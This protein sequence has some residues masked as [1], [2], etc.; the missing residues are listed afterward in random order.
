MQ[1]H[2]TYVNFSEKLEKILSLKIS[3]IPSF[4]ELFEF[5]KTYFTE[6]GWITIP[7]AI[8]YNPERKKFDKKPL[9]QWK[10]AKDVKT[11]E[12]LE[13]LWLKV[14]KGKIRDELDLNG[15]A[16]VCGEVSG[17]TVI[18][19]DDIELFKRQTGLKVNDLMQKT[20]T[21][22]SISGGLHLFFQHK[23]G[24][25]SR[26]YPNLGFDVRNDNSLI[27]LYP[28]C[29]IKPNENY[30]P[31]VGKKGD[32]ESLWGND[33]EI[34]IVGYE[35]LNTLPPAVLPK[36]FEKFLVKRQKRVLKEEKEIEKQVLPVPF[37]DIKGVI[38]EI[39]ELYEKGYLNGW[40]DI[41]ASLVG[42]LVQLGYSDERIHEILEEI[43]QEEYDERLT[44]YVIDRA[45]AIPNAKGLGSFIYKLRQILEFENNEEILEKTRKILRVFLNQNREIVEGFI[46]L[47]NT[48][49]KK[50][51]KKL[52]MVAPFVKPVAQIREKDGNRRKTYYEMEYD[53]EKFIIVIGDD[54]KLKEIIENET[55]R[56]LKSLSDFK[57]FFEKYVLKFPLPRKFIRKRTGWYGDT[58]KYP[59]KSEEN[60]IWEIDY[61]DKFITLGE[62]KEHRAFVE[63]VLKSGSDL[64]IVFLASLSSPLIYK[65][66]LNPYMVHISG[67]SGVG[68]TTA[69]KVAVNVFYDTREP[70]TL[71][72]TRNA[73]ELTLS[74]FA[75]LPVLLDEEELSRDK[76]LL[77]NLPYM[78]YSGKGKSRA[79][80]YLEVKQREI[81]S[82]VITTSEHS[83]ED[84]LN[85]VNGKNPVRKIGALRRTLHIHI[86]DRDEFYK[87]LDFK[88]ILQAIQRYVGHFGLEWITFIE[89]NPEKVKEAYE[90]A[91]A[92][93]LPAGSENIFLAIWTTYYLLKEYIGEEL[94]EL[95]EVILRYVEKQERIL[96][97]EL[98]LI[99][100]FGEE[101]T[102]WVVS[103]ADHFEGFSVEE[104][105]KEPLYGKK[106]NDTIF[107]ITTHFKDFCGQKGFSINTLLELL[108]RK[109]IL[110]RGSKGKRIM[111]KV[112]GQAVS[113][114]AINLSKLEEIAGL[115]PSESE[116]KNE[117]D[118]VKEL[119]EE[120]YNEYGEI[121]L[122]AVK[123]YKVDNNTI[124][125]INND[126]SLKAKLFERWIALKGENP[127]GF[128]DVINQIAEGKK[129]LKT[130]I[131]EYTERR[132]EEEN[133]LETAIR[134]FEEK[135]ELRLPASKWDKE[136]IKKL[137]ESLKEKGY[138][139]REWEHKGYIYIEEADKDTKE[140]LNLANLLLTLNGKISY[141]DSEI[142]AIEEVEQILS[143]PEGQ[144]FRAFLLEEYIRTQLADPKDFEDILQR[145]R[146]LRIG[147]GQALREV[148]ERIETQKKEIDGL[149]DLL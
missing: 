71:L 41:D 44:Q 82:V 46:V 58:F 20:L 146:E 76:E 119:A 92:E 75:D 112:K 136:L 109:G 145:L 135:K 127:E 47:N 95:R 133:L 132:K 97:K 137:K 68:K 45:R 120:V 129:S 122:D 101:F 72:G 134:E 114:Y 53:G 5:A 108:E 116:G 14:W 60:D 1:N 27:V 56:F 141:G 63:K 2:P 28:S 31:Q 49:Y 8:T 6:L 131:W 115:V 79:N 10:Q 77:L 23:E 88:E 26:T 52:K 62:P 140:V 94:P 89:N 40:E 9:V 42:A 138:Y 148:A 143:Q 103:N 124:K 7:V 30:K 11:L 24:I 32:L 66:N 126:N 29:A 87:G 84:T 91:T 110:V 69:G 123:F 78:L 65:L 93:R 74:K 21:Q 15:L 50:D 39:R 33:S 3:K 64:G 67:L 100:R 125:E 106:E 83:L 118:I 86:A 96:H 54:R 99:K 90:K 111:K 35:F 17:I 37:E 107:V 144:P 36:E 98:D 43:Y 113:T 57:E 55:G 117:E 102:A 80:I 142:T 81:R 4:E 16:L 128:I 34:E 104:K 105:I 13:E 70:I 18:D 22:R 19:I 48:I 51:S 139:P 38:P 147:F 12:E 25:V 61:S 130:V 149:E 121:D 85:F 59:L 73:L